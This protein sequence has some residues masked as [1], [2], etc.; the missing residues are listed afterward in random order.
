MI[1]VRER[2]DFTAQ[3]RNLK[4]NVNVIIRLF[5]QDLLAFSNSDLRFFVAGIT[6][7]DHALAVFVADA[8]CGD[9]TLAVFVAGEAF[10]DSA[11]A[12]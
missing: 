8:A 5:A 12:V 6:F 3:R 4:F 11:L 2:A 9:S 1:C 10:S 7:G